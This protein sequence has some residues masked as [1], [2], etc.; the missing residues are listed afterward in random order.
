MSI[1]LIPTISY[2]ARDTVWRFGRG[3]IRTKLPRMLIR[4]PATS[5]KMTKSLLGSFVLAL[6]LHGNFATACTVFEFMQSEIPLNST[7]IPN[8]FR[9]ELVEMMIKARTWPDTEI[10]GV[11]Q[12]RAYRNEKNPKTLLEQ[13]G[14]SL[15][16]YLLQLGVKEEN[17]WME[18]LVLDE[19][20]ARNAKGKPDIHQLNVTLY[21]ICEGSCARL[22]N[23]PRVTPVSKAIK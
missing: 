9:V 16:R 10:R 23:D 1:R 15:K 5:L 21:P 13:R 19:R 3:A 4:S 11:V 2:T 20:E 12:P 17:V 6:C 14:A 22:C 18:P 7:E 8:T